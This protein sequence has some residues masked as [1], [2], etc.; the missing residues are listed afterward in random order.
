MNGS[1][2][3]VITYHHAEHRLQYL[4]TVVQN[5]LDTYKCNFNIVIVSNVDRKEFLNDASVLWA[6]YSI[7]EH[8][9]HLSWKSREVINYYKDNFDWFL[10]IEDD[11]LI[12][13]EAY[14][15]Y[16]EKFVQLWPNYVPSFIR[17]EKDENGVEY[18]TD[19]IHRQKV[20]YIV[21]LKGRKYTSF[22]FPM[23]Y[24]A[25]WCMSRDSLSQS[26][27]P[28]FVRL[29]DSRETAASYPTWEL[30][31]KALVEIEKVDGNWQVTDNCKI[32]HIANNY[33]GKNIL[34]LATIKVED[35]FL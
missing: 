27:R 7:L 34:G 29:S 22:Q 32:Y 33:V 23:N 35:I 28:D 4:K 24:C 31:K 19:I 11:M 13:F 9:F 14:K 10:Y 17:V 20:K 21:D 25:C 30:G 5:I 12:P 16:T 2:L 18:V 6:H 15:S 8:P 3:I 1:L 26:M